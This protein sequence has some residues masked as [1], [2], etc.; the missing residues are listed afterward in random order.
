MHLQFLATKAFGD[1]VIAVTAIERGRPGPSI[2]AGSH[3]QPLA[4]ALASE[5]PTTF[6]AH[7]DA[8][9][10]A[11]FDSR[12]AGPTAAVRSGI[13]LRRAVRASRQ[14]NSRLVLDRAGPRERFLAW[15]E[16]ALVL[17]RRQNV[18]AA[19]RDL[20]ADHGL[21]SRVND[22]N[23]NAG[24][25][26]I[27]GVFPGSRLAA[28]N[29]PASLVKDVLGAAHNRG[30]Q[31]Q[32]CLLD[33]ERPDL[34]ASGLPFRL[35]PRSFS[36]LMAAIASVGKVVSADSLPAHLAERAGTPVFVVSPRENAYWLPA[37]SF[38]KRRWSL[39]GDG[40]STSLTDFLTGH[41]A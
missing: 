3:L 29:L 11:L 15:P 13:A 35:V 12:K 9:V 1:L 36:A 5:V 6:F 14:R 22:F 27:I 21:A 20:L 28:K 34:E 25:K 24:R 8:G 41:E 38:L 23:N 7:T 31:A 16:R 19:Y 17:P 40:V 4:Q 33:G 32:L 37:S 10:P 39:F 2:L 26:E 18:Y 30:V